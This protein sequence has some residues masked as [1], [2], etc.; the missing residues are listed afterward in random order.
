MKLRQII[1]ASLSQKISNIN[2]RLG[3]NVYTN[4]KAK[5][6][7]RILLICYTFVDETLI[8]FRFILTYLKHLASQEAARYYK[9]SLTIFSSPFHRY[10]LLS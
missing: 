8:V 6:A 9:I 4:V 7:K 2:F 3:F 1:F 10:P 5:K